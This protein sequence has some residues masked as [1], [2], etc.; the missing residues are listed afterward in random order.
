M[1]L[2]AAACVLTLL[3]ASSPAAAATW[4]EVGDAGN[5]PSSAQSTAGTGALTQIQGHLDNN[6]DQD[7]Y[8]IRIPDAQ[9]FS[10]QIICT[11][12]ADNDV[13]LFNA[14]ANGV[15][16]NDACAFSQTIVGTPL[17]PSA[18]LY[19]LAVS[20]SGDD[21]MNG[22]L[23]IWNPPSASGQRAPDGPGAPGPIS[24]WSNAGTVSNNN[25][26]TIL[27]NGGEFCD[28]A[29]AVFPLSWGRVKTFYR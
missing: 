22:T 27:I 3:I 26:Y 13:W 21:A 24:G 23:P 9:N 16:L 11:S 7:V 14:A 28:P 19:Y 1:T 20:P 29:T 6:L 5:L 2:R 12:F 25:N 4:T 10:A 18:G 17:V 15:A 8:C